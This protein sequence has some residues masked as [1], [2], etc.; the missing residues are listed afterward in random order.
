MSKIQNI[1]RTFLK[2]GWSQRSNTLIGLIQC[3]LHDTCTEKQRFEK[4]SYLGTDPPWKYDKCTV[5]WYL[6]ILNNHSSKSEL[7][8]QQVLFFVI[9]CETGGHL[10]IHFA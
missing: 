1:A 10:G 2:N 9:F 6:N 8:H 5:D 4:S 7:W 3:G